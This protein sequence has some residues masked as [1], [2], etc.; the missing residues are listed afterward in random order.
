M[1]VKT[2][3]VQYC[4]EVD[5]YFGLAELDECKIKVWTKLRGRARPADQISQTIVHEVV[6][7]ILNETRYKDLC[8]DEDFVERFSL[9]LHQFM[10]TAK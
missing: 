9:L 3:A 4:G 1:V 6:H 2:Y 8:H 5:E 10:E 7:C